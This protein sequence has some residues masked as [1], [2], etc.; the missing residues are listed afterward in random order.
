MHRILVGNQR[1]RTTS[2][3]GSL[4]FCAYL[5]VT[6]YLSRCCLVQRPSCI[7]LLFSSDLRS[8]TFLFFF[9]CLLPIFDREFLFSFCF[10]PIFDP[11]LSLF[12]KRVSNSIV[13]D[14]F[15]SWET[16]FFLLPRTGM[17]VLILGQGLWWFEVFGQKACRT[18]GHDEC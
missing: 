11:E 16:P 18:A 4:C 14:F 13:N 7:F 17:E 10:L 12:W 8:G 2:G 3:R 5:V 9:F 1:E 6:L 15:F